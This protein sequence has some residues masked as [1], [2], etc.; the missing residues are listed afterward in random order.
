MKAGSQVFGVGLLR[1]GCGGNQH[2]TGDKTVSQQRG[3]VELLPLDLPFWCD[4][5]IHPP[6]ET[7]IRN[8][9]Q[10]VR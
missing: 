1:M 3:H 10:S 9:Q 7:R 5:G 6:G 4:A 8:R 2:G